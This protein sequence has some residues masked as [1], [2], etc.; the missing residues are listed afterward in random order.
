MLKKLVPL[1]LVIM[2]AAVFPGKLAFSQE[3]PNVTW[4][5]VDPAD[6]QVGKSYLIVSEHGALANS[7]ATISTPGDVNS[8][9]IGMTS[10]PVTI[11]DGL[12]TSEV[13]E[14]MI[15]QFGLGANSAAASGGLGEGSGY[16]LLN[17]APGAG[18][19]TEPLRRESS[20]N[21]Q[22]APLNTTSAAINGNQQSLLMHVLNENEGTV[23]LYFWNGNNQWN[24]ALT[25]TE[26]GFTAKSKVAGTTSAAQLLQQMQESP[27]LQ[28]YEPNLNLGVQHSII[29][30]SGENGSISPS[31]LTGHVWVNDGEDVTFTFHPSFGFEVD[32]VTVNDEEVAFTD[33]K[34]TI[35]NV[36]TN[37]TKIHVTF[38]PYSNATV[39]PF[40]VYNDIF[41][42]GNVTT[43]VVVDLGEGNATNLADLSANMFTVAARNTRLDGST[44]IF[45]GLRNITRVYVNNKPEPLGYI[46]PTPGSGDLI[47]DT[48]TSGRYIVVEF[49]FWNANGYTSGSMVSGNL[50]NQ[51]Q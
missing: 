19:G 50:Q 49:E 42:V 29:A 27:P 16:Y 21:A 8:T 30:S 5:K 9:Q 1:L 36:I 48:P 25:S 31:S 11:E 51:C 43:A 23:S 37:G 34:Y 22:H 38:K 18:G 24:F 35:R 20:F 47:T 28:L 13:T 41:S 26:D 40:T 17:N 39:L 7:Q 6:V 15:W 12:I 46:S 10:K 32:K 33:N 45:D 44:V 4:K 3:E 14:D 2:I